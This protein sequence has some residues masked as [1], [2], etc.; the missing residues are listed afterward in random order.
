MCTNG[1]YTLPDGTTVNSTGLYSSILKRKSGCDSIIFIIV[2]ASPPVKPNLGADTCF[3]TAAPIVLRAN[4]NLAKSYL[5][6]DGSTDSVYS[7]TMPGTYWVQATNVC[8]A[9]AD[10]LVIYPQ[11]LLPVY[12]PTA[13]TPNGDGINDIFRIG[14][15]K[16]QT[17]LDFSIYNRWGTLVFRTEDPAQGWDGNINA[18]PAPSG[19]FVYLIHYNDLNGKGNY[20][21]GTVVLMR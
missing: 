10:T 4:A 21:K 6:Q 2:T 1:S 14:D 3:A 18:Q 12:V 20:I 7:A 9:F 19:A 15:M 5:W 11:C 8:G 17:L 16:G 13:F